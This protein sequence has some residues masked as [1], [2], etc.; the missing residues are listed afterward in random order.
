[1]LNRKLAGVYRCAM[2]LGLSVL[3]ATAWGCTTPRERALSSGK[4]SAAELRTS[5]NN[6]K[7]MMDRVE[8]YLRQI[9]ST[10]VESEP[11]FNKFSAALDEMRRQANSLRYEAESM[12]LQ[13]ANYFKAWEREIGRAPGQARTQEEQRRTQ[14][15]RR[16]D[17][18]VDAMVRAKSEYRQYVLELLDLREAL[19]GDLSRQNI[20]NLSKS[21]ELV[22]RDRIEAQQAIDVL[23]GEIDR[24]MQAQVQ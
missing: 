12:Q 2:V 20:E 22:K 14:A 24:V 18:V 23:L 15:S 16:Y 13:G 17:L 5:L 7:P 8:T 9:E 1:M 19:E 4:M 11:A 21:F 3:V 6:L 10:A